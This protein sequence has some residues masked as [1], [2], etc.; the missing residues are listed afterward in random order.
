MHH[1]F[2][3]LHD[4]YTDWLLKTMTLSSFQAIRAVYIVNK[5]ECAAPV[6]SN[7]LGHCTNFI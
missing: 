6:T 1:A 3:I 4:F 5:S 7:K 2:L